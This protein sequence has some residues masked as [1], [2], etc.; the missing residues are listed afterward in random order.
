MLRSSVVVS[1]VALAVLVAASSAAARVV[2]APE[3]IS[4]RGRVVQGI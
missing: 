2:V 4:P 1:F 3:P